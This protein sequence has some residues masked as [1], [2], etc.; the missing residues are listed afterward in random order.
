MC[1]FIFR[2]PI[3]Q[4]GSFA[5]LAPTFAILTLERNKCPADF[6]TNGWGDLPNEN[7]TEE[8]QRRMR[9]I[10]GSIAVASIFQL[11]VGFGGII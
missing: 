7:K 4:G 6:E 1:K 11:V 3:I 10:Q 8:W 9:E 2:L 5:F